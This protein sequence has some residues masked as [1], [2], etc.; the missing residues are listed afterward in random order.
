M[1]MY[2]LKKL[3]WFDSAIYFSLF[4]FLKFTALNR[5]RSHLPQWLNLWKLV[6]M[7]HILTLEIL[8]KSALVRT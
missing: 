7:P 8:R 2:I 5:R 4:P 1:E 6:K 3:C